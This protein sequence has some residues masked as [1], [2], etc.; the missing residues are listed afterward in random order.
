MPEPRR[1]GLVDA[2][3]RCYTRRWRTRHG[4]EAAEVALM[5]MRDG[6]PAR[7][8]AWSYLKGA[9][10]ERLTPRPGRRFAAA[11]AALLASASS[12]GVTLALLT[13]SVPASAASSAH[14]RIT[15]RDDSAARLVMLLNCGG[16]LGATV[17][18]ALPALEARHVK[19][20]WDLTGGRTGGDAVPSSSYYVAGGRA[21]SPV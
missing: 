9:A 16:L 18:E 17:G 3:L 21:L 15:R 8:I 7:S 5:L 11:A 19:I 10:R 6:V 14:A 12:L 4:D 20:T 1:A 2:A 13:A